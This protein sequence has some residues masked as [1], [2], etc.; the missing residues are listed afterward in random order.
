MD[1]IYCG[2]C[3]TEVEDCYHIWFGCSFAQQCW[4]FVH[5][6]YPLPVWPSS[7]IELENLLASSAVADEPKTCLAYVTWS[8]WNARNEKGV[9]EC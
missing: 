9:Q 7:L 3:L 4:N 6:N 8:L 5:T 1:M 2:L